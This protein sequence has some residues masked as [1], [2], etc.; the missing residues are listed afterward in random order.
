MK[1]TA[2]GIILFKTHYKNKLNKELSGEGKNVGHMVL[3]NQCT[4]EIPYNE[5]GIFSFMALEVA[6]F[7]L[8]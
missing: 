4:F 6:D 1:T 8:T 3:R 7:I 5:E 2:K